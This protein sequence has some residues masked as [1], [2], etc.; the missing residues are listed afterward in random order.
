LDTNEKYTRVA[1]YLRVSTE[2]Q[3][4]QNISIPSQKS[5]LI[6]YCES[7]QWEIFDFYID[8]GFT[9]KN[10][11]RPEMQRMIADSNNN[12]FDIILVIKLDRLS[13]R[14]QHVMYLIEDIL[15]PNHIDFASVT[16]NFD[17][18]TPMGRAMLGIMA[19]F[20]QL[21]RETIVERVLDAKIEA[22]R[23]G[24]WQGGT[25]LYGYTHDSTT[26]SIK[27]NEI[28]AETVR[29]IF[30]EYLKG[31]KGYAA[32]ADL[33]TSKNIPTPGNSEFWYTQ[34]VRSILRNPSYVGLT[35]HKGTTYEGKHDAI[36]PIET[37]QKAQNIILN[38]AVYKKGTGDGL[39][40]GLIYCGECEA[41][42]R[43]KP[44]SRK[45]GKHEYYY[46]CYSRDKSARSMI[47]DK[48]C[49]NGHHR[50][51]NIDN[52]IIEKLINYSLNPV[53]FEKILRQEASQKG[54]IN[55]PIKKTLN[56]ATK[57][58]DITKKGL[59]KW[60]DAYI[61]EA[62]SIDEF[63]ELTKDLKEK[64]LFLEGKIMEYNELLSNET[65]TESKIEIVL[66][67]VFNLKNSWPEMSQEE[68]RQTVLSIITKVILFKDKFID[69][70][71]L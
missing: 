64:R 45:N 16:E 47:K 32:I 54:N 27:V 62:I 56:A 35:P 26:K 9:G 4:E 25:V 6:S 39:F 71:F 24:R 31:D 11:D 1:A 49:P 20:A 2:E 52:A 43:A 29:F 67:R 13:R 60:Q 50:S 22:A 65:E 44:I 3:A 55:D 10:L 7:R 38:R 12:K 8:D 28:E 57:E 46:V 66:E 21:E 14:Q 41:K 34:T 58:L 19:V 53:V 69:L 36:I 42:I 61:A 59:K 70:Y 68:K 30:N 63:R 5:R 51:A 15:T 23:Q 33:L 18:S 40:K 48:N 17:T 37:W